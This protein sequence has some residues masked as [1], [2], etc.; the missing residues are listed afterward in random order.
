MLILQDLE[1]KPVGYPANVKTNCQTIINQSGQRVLADGI[2]VYEYPELQDPTVINKLGLMYD[3]CWQDLDRIIAEDPQ[4]QPVYAPDNLNYKFTDPGVY[5]ITLMMG[6]L[7]FDLEGITYRSDPASVRA[8]IIVTH[9]TMTFNVGAAAP[10]VNKFV[11]NVGV[12]IQDM[13]AGDKQSWIL[14]DNTLD[15][16]DHRK[17]LLQ[18]RSKWYFSSCGTL[19]VYLSSTETK[20]L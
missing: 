3:S 2:N 15:S 16:G 13:N 1:Y 19:P 12:S 8:S 17:N 10:S 7:G 11:S 20:I 4:G 18:K 14:A 5:Q 6:G 9:K